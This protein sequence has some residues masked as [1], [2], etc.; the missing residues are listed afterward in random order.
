MRTRGRYSAHDTEKQGEGW[1]R[2]TPC[3]SLSTDPGEGA[4]PLQV[5]PEA[6]IPGSG[7]EPPH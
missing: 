3:G 7:H 1:P 4:V 2:W 6:E 5:G